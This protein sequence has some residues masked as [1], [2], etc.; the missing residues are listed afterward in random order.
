MRKE[1][2][3]FILRSSNSFYAMGDT[4]GQAIKRFEKY[5]GHKLTDSYMKGDSLTIY[6]F[7]TSLPMV[8]IGDKREHGEDEADAYC[9]NHGNVCW[10]PTDDRMRMTKIVAR[11]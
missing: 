4:L 3:R 7:V 9:N 5:S 8:K 10:Y 2:E 1:N 11:L 6:H